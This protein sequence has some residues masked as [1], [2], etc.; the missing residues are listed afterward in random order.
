MS[1]ILVTGGAG[2]IASE[3]ATRLAEK[4]DNEVVIVDNLLTGSRTKLPSGKL[5]NVSFIKCDVNNYE[6]ISS[7]FY[8]H[9]FDYVFHY[10]QEQ[11]EKFL[12]M[13]VTL[14]P[15]H[16]KVELDHTH[17]HVP[18][19]SLPEEERVKILNKCRERVR[20]LRGDDVIDVESVKVLNEGD[21]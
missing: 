9:G 13:I 11:P 5:Q 19:M 17:V 1:K 18:V 7:V 14:L 10:A 20:E 3:L 21:S 8:S 6:N 15:K 16:L 12:Q 2:F 4:K